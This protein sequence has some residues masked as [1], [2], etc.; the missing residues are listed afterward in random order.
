MTHTVVSAGD[1]RL[2]GGIGFC[3]V[4]ARIEAIVVLVEELR[5][6]MPASGSVPVF[7]DSR[8]TPHCAIKVEGNART[9]ATTSKKKR[10]K[11]TLVTLLPVFFVSSSTAVATITDKRRWHGL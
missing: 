8:S 1:T 2:F 10:R 3:V 5:F 9:P 11:F 7:T 6:T 4:K